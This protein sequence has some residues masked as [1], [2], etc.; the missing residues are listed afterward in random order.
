M[1]KISLLIFLILVSISGAT[2]GHALTLDNCVQKALQTHPDIKRFILQVKHSQE[3]VKVAQADYL[4][5]LSLNAEYD[6]TTTY[7][8]PA[9]GT[10]QTQRD[11]GWRAGATL[12]QKIWDFSKT[13]SLIK[14]Q[15]TQKEIANLSLQDAKALLAYKVKLQY[16][17]A[18]VQQKAIFVRQKDLKAKEELYKQALALVKQGMKTHADSTRLLSSVYVAKDNLAIAE[19]DLDKAKTTLA[20]YINEPIP[21]TAKLEDSLSASYAADTVNETSMLQNSISLKILQS[22]QAKSELLYKAAKAAHYGSIDAIASYNHQKTLNTYA[23]SMVGI[24]LNIPL[25]SGG[26]LAAQEKQAIIDK[27]SAKNEFDAK[28][29]E[30]KEEFARLLI[31]LKRYKYTIKAKTSQLQAA[32]QTKTVIKA[33]YKEGLATYIEVLDATAL[34]L[35]AQLGLL[36]ANY[37]QR[38]IMHR[39]EYLQGKTI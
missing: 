38:S 14:V 16:E 8:M 39:I 18:L 28:V 25:Y 2:K 26:R 34:S 20:L 24:M 31:D 9:N 12:K 27:Q 7:V 1:K 17:L 11:D 15:K 5:Q 35:D 29:L 13:T 10:F 32:D 6:P 21:K 23:T 3:G 4:P 36:E 22:N 19:S 33:R 30:L 37:G